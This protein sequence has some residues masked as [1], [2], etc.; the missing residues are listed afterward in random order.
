M[1]IHYGT[2]YVNCGSTQEESRKDFLERKLKVCNTCLF[3]SRFESKYTYGIACEYLWV[4]GAMRPCKPYECI[5][6][7]VYIKRNI[8]K[9]KEALRIKED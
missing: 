7:G 5:E 8:S 3:G 6:K 2:R 4:T 9:K 1:S